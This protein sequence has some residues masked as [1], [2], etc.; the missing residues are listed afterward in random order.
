MPDLVDYEIVTRRVHSR[1]DGNLFAIEHGDA[2]LFDFK[3]I[4]FIQSEKGSKRGEHAHKSCS[5]WISALTGKVQITLKN[6]ASTD[7]VHLQTL[8]ELL[9]VPP[10]IWV[11]IDFIESGVIAVGAD[12]PYQESDYIRQWGDFLEYKRKS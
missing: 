1:V 6:G 9:V 12:M 3:R 8:G 2:N 7:L 5:Q 4:F 11:E 10:G